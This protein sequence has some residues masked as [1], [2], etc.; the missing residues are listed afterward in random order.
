MKNTDGPKT[1]DDFHEWAL[2][3]LDAAADAWLKLKAIPENKP[4]P[5]DVLHDYT[6][7]CS[8]ACQYWKTYRDMNADEFLKSY[9]P[10]EDM[11]IGKVQCGK[12]N[13]GKDDKLFDKLT[14]KH[15]NLNKKW[16]KT[17]SANCG[18]PYD[19]K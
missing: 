4:L 12:W 5:K 13:P 1:I 3:A 2:C 6:R 17:S 8:A 18:R 10:Q 19:S 16:K 15:P 14:A 7:L 9:K 11:W